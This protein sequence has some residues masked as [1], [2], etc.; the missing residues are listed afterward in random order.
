MSDSE[1]E[2]SNY[3]REL[4]GLPTDTF[5]LMVWPEKAQGELAERSQGG[6]VV[7]DGGTAAPGTA[8]WRQG[9]N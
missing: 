6:A 4:K 7:H 9:L 8:T 2:A 5:T 3:A 1:D